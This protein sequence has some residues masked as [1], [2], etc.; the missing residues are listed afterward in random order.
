EY[1]AEQAFR[2]AGFDVRRGFYYDDEDEQGHP[3]R[4]EIDVVAVRQGII[5]C[6]LPN[7]DPWNVRTTLGFFIESK[8]VDKDRKDRSPG[9]EDVP[10]RPWVAFTSPHHAF[11]RPG[12]LVLPVASSLGRYAIYLLAEN[13]K[14]LRL[15]MFRIPE[16]AGYSLVSAN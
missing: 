5:P 12:G 2:E 3:T 8:H 10:G 14:G 15:P 16:R 4:R 6:P 13:H 1:E 11:P 9:A 7:G